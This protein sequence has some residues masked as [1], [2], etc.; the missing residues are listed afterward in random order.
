[1]LSTKNKTWVEI[2]RSA[3]LYNFQTLQKIVGKKVKVAPVVKANAYGHGLAEVVSILKN[4][5]DIFA[6]DNIDEAFIIRK[7]DKTVKVLIL[8]YT[9]KENIKLTIENNFSFVVYSLDIL[10]YIISL[11][12]KEK[13]KIH[14]KIETGL[15]RQGVEGKDLIKILS[16]VKKN[17]DRI[18]LEGVYTHFA[19]VE[20]TLDSSFAQKQLK[21]FKDT[22]K[23]V[24]TWGFNPPLIHTAASAASFLYKESHFSMIRAG[25][26]LYGLWPSRETRIALKSKNKNISLKPVLTWKS[27]V[28]QVKIVRKGE[29]VGYGRTWISEQTSKI[30]VI[31]AGYSDGFDRKLSNLGRVIVGGSYAPVVGR[32]AMNMIMI[33]IT[34]IKRVNDG[35]EV[36]IIGKM[37]KLE[38]PADE[39]AE[40]IGTINY[41]VISRINPI[42]PRIIV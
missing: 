36:V 29:S 8:G 20:D 14:I 6:V 39:L 12:L 25:V 38:V 42:L 34:H 27:I 19:N 21:R 5:T 9:T 32:V 13:A 41:E 10:R 22:L 33:D 7:I 3:L 11:K 24:R 23:I 2:S 30:A 18:F 35:D 15:N 31:P 26:A 37:G 40:K 4:K 16:F 17:A 1:M 28:A